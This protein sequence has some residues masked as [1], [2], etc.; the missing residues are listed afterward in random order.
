MAGRLLPRLDGDVVAAGYGY[1]IRYD[2][3]MFKQRI[4]N[5]S[6][7]EHP[8]NWPRYGNLGVPRPEVLCPGQSSVD[9]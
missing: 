3:G 1:G 2:Y 6:Q 9:G 7:I 5:G 4:E 8:D